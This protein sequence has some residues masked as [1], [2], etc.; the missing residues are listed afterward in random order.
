MHLFYY[1]LYFYY[2]ILKFYKLRL[3]I[4]LFKSGHTVIT[5]HH[6][7]TTPQSSLRTTPHHN[8][9]T[10]KHA[11]ITTKIKYLEADLNRLNSQCKLFHIIEI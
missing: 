8:Q 11:I 9:P 7:H 6:S 5:P 3:D 4:G 2:M 1:S 10:N